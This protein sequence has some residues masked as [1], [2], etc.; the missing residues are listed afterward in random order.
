MGRSQNKFIK[1]QKA[2]KKKKKQD[3]KFQKRQERKGQ[4][5]SSFEDMIAYVDEFGNVTSTPPEEREKGEED[6]KTEES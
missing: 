4:E 2:N 3:E 6:E 5:S 1:Q